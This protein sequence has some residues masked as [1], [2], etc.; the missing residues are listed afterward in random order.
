MPPTLALLPARPLTLTFARRA[1][2]LGVALALAPAAAGCGDEQGT[3]TGGETTTPTFDY[4]KDG[5]LRINHLQAKGTHNSYHVAPDDDLLVPI[6]YTHA[7]LDVQLASQG[8][9]HFELDVRYDKFKDAFTVFHETFDKGTT[10]ATLV[11]CLSTMKGWSDAHPAHHVLFVQIEL[12]DSAA[13]DQ[14]E[15]YFARLEGEVLSVFDRSRV[16]TPD[17]VRGDAASVRDAIVSKGWPTLGEGRGKLAFFID[18][19][20]EMRTYYT[21][22][23][24]DL[25]GRLM[26]IDA[27]PGDAWAGILLAND[28]VGDAAR[29][30]ES[31]QLGLIVRTRAD[32]DNEEPLAGDTTRRDAAFASG[33]QLVSTDYPAK[34]DGVDY[35]VDV[36]G[37]TPSR[38]SPVTAPAGCTSEDIEDPA[39]IGD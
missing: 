11:E 27:E 3:S 31:L 16:L 5:E 4:P 21:H 35:V 36:P 13:E 14:A 18:N 28:P 20:S 24:V 2:A 17:D 30:A 29:I 32:S 10:C 25:E 9:R 8:A 37:G 12:K 1:L 33:A 38:C 23:G 22:G 15:D 7:P 19:S 6:D 34:V 39:F 26:F